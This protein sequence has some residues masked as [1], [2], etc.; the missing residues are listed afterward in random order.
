M[1]HPVVIFCKNVSIL[2][3]TV[4]LEGNKLWLLV[5]CSVFFALEVFLS[6][7]EN[8]NTA[9]PGFWSLFGLFLLESLDSPEFGFLL[10][11]LFWNQC[12]TKFWNAP[13]WAEWV[14]FLYQKSW[15]FIRFHEI[16]L[17]SLS[18]M[19]FEIELN[20]L[21][22]RGTWSDLEISSLLYASFMLYTKGGFWE[23][24]TFIAHR[25]CHLNDRV[26]NG[27]APTQ[28]M[29]SDLNLVSALK[30]VSI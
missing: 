13:K 15:N 11:F 10:D 28:Y 12:I 27:D 14:I 9:D 8:V 6:I 19:K 23:N 20:E 16:F 3:H 1:K 29:Y 26:W 5:N 7:D 24:V 17:I 2:N 25:Y 18:K 22:A 4:P 21:L 30:F